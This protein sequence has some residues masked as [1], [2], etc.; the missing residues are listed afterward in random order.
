MP[1]YIKRL[2]LKYKHCM[3][4]QPQHCPYSP[5][6]KQYGA[7]AQTPL[8]VDVTL[9]LSPEEI[10]EI[11]C[12]VGS[13]LQYACTVDLTVLMALSSIAIKQTKGTTNTMQKG[14]QLLD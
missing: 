12:V 1:G 9:R 13:I 11:H 6:P 10:K 3:P 5:S 7:Q 8:L 2:F 4:N 14:K